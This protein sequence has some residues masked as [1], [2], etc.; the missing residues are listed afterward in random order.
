MK[1]SKP[2]ALSKAEVEFKQMTKRALAAWYE[3]DSLKKELARIKSCLKEKSELW[4]TVSYGDFNGKGKQSYIICIKGIAYHGE[5][6]ESALKAARE[7][8]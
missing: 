4:D 3:R 8:E 6:L 7:G 1:S 2:Q 5:T